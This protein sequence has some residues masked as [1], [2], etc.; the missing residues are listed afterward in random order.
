M[1]SQW[2]NSQSTHLNEGDQQ[3]SSIPAIY[4]GIQLAEKIY[5]TLNSN[6]GPANNQ[7]LLYFLKYGQKI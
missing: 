4:A 1:I 5:G 6:E 3:S 2:P 7:I